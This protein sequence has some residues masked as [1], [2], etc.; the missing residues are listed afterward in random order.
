MS[1][2]PPGAAVNTQTLLRTKYPGMLP[3]EAQLFDAWFQLHHTEFDTAGFNVRVGQGI[4]PGPAYDLVI[5]DMAIIN[6]QFRLDALLSR[7]GLYY[8]VEVKIRPTPLAIGQL[9][10]YKVL[11]MQDNPSKGVP[12]LMLLSAGSSPDMNTVCAAYSITIIGQQ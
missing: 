5:R 4:D 12:A 9:L 3:Q 10:A 7:Q 11:W 1:T 8:I 2:T 6:S